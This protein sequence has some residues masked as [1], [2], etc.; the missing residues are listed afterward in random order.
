M[1]QQVQLVATGDVG[2]FIVAEC[3]PQAPG[4]GEIRLRHD[5]IGVN[6]IDIYHRMGL[7]PLPLPAVLGVEGAGTV[8]AVG[9]GVSNVRVGERVAYAG[10]PGAYAATRLLPAWRAISLPD[11]IDTKVAAVSFLRGMTAHM[12]L[13]RVYPAAR[14]T[15]VL[16]HAAAGGLGATLTRWAHDLGCTVIGTASSPEKASLAREHGADHVIVGR[17]ADVAAE[18]ARLTDGKGVDFAVDGIGGDMLRKTL[19]STRPLGVVASVGQA[20]G[21]IPPVAVSELRPMLVR[22]SIMAYAADQEAYAV[23]AQAVIAAIRQ[24]IVRGAAHE[25][26]LARAAQAHGDLE[27]GKTTGS[28][29]L[30]P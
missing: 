6:F 28:V 5:G 14:G 2:N 29:M 17:A 10:I 16:V 9:E 27:S 1:D 25:Y 23:A 15:I 30:A 3:A 8:E 12:L 19:A 11:G 21:P 24:G 18:V 13:T 22:P 4:P 26:P 7:Y 20:G